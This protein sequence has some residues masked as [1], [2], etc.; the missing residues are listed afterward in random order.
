MGRTRL[1]E[2]DFAAWRTRFRRKLETQ[3]GSAFAAHAIEVLDGE[4][5]YYGEPSSEERR[6]YEATIPV[7]ARKLK[8]AGRG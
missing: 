5:A 3:Y 8:E 7:L 6:L 2:S 1:I 4:I